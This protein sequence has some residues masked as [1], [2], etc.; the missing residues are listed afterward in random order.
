MYDEIPPPRPRDVLTIVKWSI[1][2]AMI[3]LIIGL[4][5]SWTGLIGS[6]GTAPSRVINKTLQTDNIIESYEW[7]FN[8][9]AQ[10]DARVGQ[11]KT[12]SDLVAA[13]NDDPE[14]RRLGIELAAM[15]QSCRELATKYNANSA[16]MNKQAFKSDNLPSELD[17]AT[18]E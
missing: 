4:I 7:F 17:V 2:V 3:G 5:L 13:T 9:N 12:H 14:K 15:R 11:I 16:K 8:T 6:I 1:A 18:C 10:F